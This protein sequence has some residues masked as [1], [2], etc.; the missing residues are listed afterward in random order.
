MKT[1]ANSAPTKK[2]R[3]SGLIKLCASI[4]VGAWLTVK[5]FEIYTLGQ[6]KILVR[7]LIN[8]PIY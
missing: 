8:H 6:L 4:K 1:T 5:C 2:W 7:Q 3:F